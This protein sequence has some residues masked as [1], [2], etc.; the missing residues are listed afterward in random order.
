MHEDMYMYMHFHAF[1]IVL[2]HVMMMPLVELLLGV[3]YIV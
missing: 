1:P 2:C 3:K